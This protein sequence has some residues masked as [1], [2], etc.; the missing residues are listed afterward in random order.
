MNPKYPAPQIDNPPTLPRTRF[1]V[2][3]CP[4]RGNRLFQHET[5]A[6]ARRGAIRL[7]RLRKHTYYVLEC[8]GVA[9]RP[10]VEFLRFKAEH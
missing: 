6:A 1:W 4:Q 3:W 2:V 9:T 10:P 7:A 8:V 5:Y